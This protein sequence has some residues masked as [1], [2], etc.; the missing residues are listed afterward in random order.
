M[1]VALLSDI[2]GHITGLKAVFA[3]LDR[4][5]G[6]D[7]TY[8]LGD[9][10]GGGPGTEDVLDL[11]LD[12]QVQMLRGNWD[13]IFIDL[14]AHLTRIPEGSHVFVI[15]TF[16]W[17]ANELSSEY[18]TLLANLPFCETL[19]LS[20]KHRL[21]LCH[22]TPQDTWARVCRAN[23]PTTELRNAYGHLDAQVIAY[24]HYHAH[25]LLP[26]DNKLLIN[27]ASI[28]LGWQGLSALT[29]VESFQDQ[30]SIQQYQVPYDIHEHDR[31][32]RERSMP[33][34]P[35]IWYW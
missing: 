7:I 24:G 15:Q 9:F 8:A 2:H 23:T 12:R 29:L 3:R 6:A 35:A 20:Q 34:D 18:Q 10:V 31:L 33:Y 30:I 26:L 32:V 25:H 11:L 28:G 4:L 22:A 16:E 27:V 13:E 21:L 19:E 1:R 14:N 5:G 17:L